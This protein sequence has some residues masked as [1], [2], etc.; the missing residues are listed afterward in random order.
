[1]GRTTLAES[2]QVVLE[3]LL[4]GVEA[5]GDHRLLQLLDVVNTLSTGHDLLTT[6]EEVI[7][8][9]EAGV[10]R[11]GLG[12][13]RTDGHRELVEHVEIGVVL[14]TNDLSQLLLH[15]G[16]EVVLEALLL[17]DI[18]TGLLQQSNTVH[19]VQ[20]E[21]LAI[22]GELEVTGL[23]VR[24]L[25]D[26][27]LVGVA[28]L[29]LGEDEDEEVFGELQNL[30]VVA[31]ESLLE[32]E[33]GELGKSVYVRKLMLVIIWAYLS[34]VSVGVAVFGTE[35]GS[36]FENALHVTSN[37]HLLVQLGTLGQVGVLLEVLDLK[38]VATTLGSRT[39]QLG[40]E[41]PPRTALD[42][43]FGEQF[44]D[45][46]GDPG[47]SLAGFGLEIEDP[48]V[49]TGLESDNRSTI[50]T[51][52]ESLLAGLRGRSLGILD[53]H[54]EHLGRLGDHVDLADVDFVVAKGSRRDGHGRLLDDTG[55]LDN[56]VDVQ[57]T[58]VLDHLTGDG[59]RK[60]NDGLQLLTLL[61]Q[62][63]ESQ[64]GTLHT[65]IVDASHQGNLLL[66][67]LV[68]DVGESR[69][70]DDI[71]GLGELAI[72]VLGGVVG[73]G[74]SSL[75]LLLGSTS[76]SLLSLG[77]LLCG[78]LRGVLASALA[79]LGTLGGGGR[80]GGGFFG[81]GASGQFGVRHGERCG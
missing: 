5:L 41:D 18:D 2:R 75:S 23:G 62:H 27:D 6:H 31:A 32:I 44:G 14:V 50:L 63:Q 30:V 54:R 21:S 8:V 33:T 55:D 74:G 40:G 19:V 29:E 10:L 67:V 24:L 65:G 36:N 64:L 3:S 42:H 46:A 25:D 66:V 76:S 45:A 81:L 61:S 69:R 9:G 80:S 37:A 15:R 28:L 70:G 51:N 48:V 11:A 58:S 26:G 22:L 52:L 71:F 17:G 43:V 20:A 78:L 60:S 49:E 77:L 35:D 73:S 59:L 12:V 34:Q 79:G 68:G 56:G 13:E 7:R 57:S 72:Q 4:V 1:M 53:L 38:D 47:D 16:G 39:H